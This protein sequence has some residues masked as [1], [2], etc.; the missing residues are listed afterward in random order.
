M[1]P[2]IHGLITIAIGIWLLTRGGI[3]PVLLGALAAGVFDASAALQLP[4]LGGSTVPPSRVMLA[5]LLIAVFRAVGQRTGLLADALRNNGLLLLYATWGLVAACTLPFVFAGQAQVVPMSAGEQIIH[6]YDVFPLRFTPQNITTPVYMM[7]TALTAMVAYVA[8]RTSQRPQSIVR[9][10]AIL[11]WVQVITGIASITLAGT[12][13]DM[14][15]DFIRNG[16]YGQLDQYFGDLRRMDGVMSEPSSFASFTFVWFVV[17]F[18]SWLND[19]DPVRSGLAALAAMVVLM[20]STS[21]TAYA[22]IAIYG[23]V[24]AIRLAASAR[25]IPVTKVVV[26]VTLGLIGLAAV[27]ALMLLNPELAAWARNLLEVNTVKK[28]TSASGLQRAFWAR[29][30]I[31]M[32]LLSHG[33][34]VGPG[35][36]RSSGFVQSVVGSCGVIGCVL[37]AGYLLQFGIVGQFG[38]IDAQKGRLKIARIVGWGAVAV[39][40]PAIL[41]GPSPDPGAIFASLAGFSIGLRRPFVALRRQGAHR[42]PGHPQSAQGQ[43]GQAEA[44]PPSRFSEAPAVPRPDAWRRRAR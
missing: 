27:I 43:W 21:T 9:L 28:A 22:A 10:A 15:V 13:W 1:I 41:S 5:F 26:L 33:L 44:Q 18:E 39:L 29:Q 31:D 23:L 40:I 4:A 3:L 17:C 25:N 36:F 20:I 35:T 12:A 37:F 32:F 24:V 34:G 19:I 38:A 2:T 11:V 30:G 42:S 7:G 8:G 14:V 6:L 16:N